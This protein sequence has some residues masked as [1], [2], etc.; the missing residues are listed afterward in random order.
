MSATPPP[1]KPTTRLDPRHEL[2]PAMPGW[3]RIPSLELGPR[4]YE[5]PPPETALTLWP[6]SEAEA[7]AA[8]LRASGRECTVDSAPQVETPDAR[9]R[10]WRPHAFL[11]EAVAAEPAGFAL[12]LAC[13]VGRESVFL[14]DR[15]WRV[16]GIDW[17]PDAL[18]RAAALE[19]RYV[20]PG[21]PPIAWCVRDLENPE[22]WRDPLQPAAFDVICCFRFLH[23]PL[24]QSAWRWLRPGGR[25]VVETFTILHQARYARPRRAALV[26]NSGELP[27]LADNLSVLH[28]SEDWHGEAHTARLIAQR[29]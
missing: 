17:L 16:V 25:L 14:A 26:L 19:R 7:A 1:L 2:A 13:G 11:E 21:A 20:A 28:F 8:W 27:Q 9:W 24:L 6:C 18:L 5:L 4:S 15:G 22:Q 3:V 10:L 12:D 29:G 23:R